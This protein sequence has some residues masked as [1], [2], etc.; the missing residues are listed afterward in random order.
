MNGTAFWLHGLWREV[1]RRETPLR[2]AAWTRAV[3]RIHP[4]LREQPLFG[5]TLARLTA[6]FERVEEEG[7]KDRTVRHRPAARPT[8]APT[9]RKRTGRWRQ[10]TS[11]R[12]PPAPLPLWKRRDGRAAHPPA[13]KE[14][15]LP[16][17]LEPRLAREP[18]LRL[19]H[20]VPQM[21]GRGRSL[22]SPS[23]PSS[24]ARRPAPGLP[25]ASGPGL[26][27]AVTAWRERLAER[28]ERALLQHGAVVRSAPAVTRWEGPESTIHLRFPLD[29]P[30][31]SRDQL[32]RASHSP[33]PLRRRT[34]PAEARPEEPLSRMEPAG[35]TGKAPS[36][37]PLAAA[38]TPP[39]ADARG[40]PPVGGSGNSP[41]SGSLGGGEPWGETLERLLEQGTATAFPP[42]PGRDSKAEGF[43]WITPPAAGG[44]APAP[45]GRNPS[46]PPATP[47]SGADPMLSPAGIT[48][49]PQNADLAARIKQILD[50]EARR[51]GI[52]V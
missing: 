1:I 39:P 43:A 18:L 41:S 52:E 31:A 21:E 34:P 26:T 8:P 6:A 28:M 42:S 37:S 17:G 3:V 36:P 9:P 12:L 45:S 51:H 7:V 30:E 48:P 25:V 20:P 5:E 22:L 23:A 35:T 2:L 10:E 50:E 13:R 11:H 46:P 15:L 32:A 40:N 38:P 29:G 24:A 33:L 49:G 19:A 47:G 16:P 27:A 44:G 14:A 4:Q